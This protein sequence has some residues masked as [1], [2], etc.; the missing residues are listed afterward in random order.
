MKD[1]QL[2]WEKAILGGKWGNNTDKKGSLGRCTVR[3]VSTMG[4]WGLIPQG[5]S[6]A[7]VK[8]LEEEESQGIYTPSLV[9]HCWKAA[10]GR[11]C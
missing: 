6:E 11:E 1:N 9:S 4:A 3:Q 8:H 2:I 10:P 5:N 7:G